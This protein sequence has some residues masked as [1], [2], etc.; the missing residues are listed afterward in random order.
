MT[1][2]KRKHIRLPDYDYSTPGAYFV[3]ICT[4]NRR[5]TLSEITVGEGL[6]PPETRLSQIGQCVEEQIQHLPHRYPTVEIEK[7]VI[8]PNHVHLLVTIRE[9]TENFNT[10]QEGIFQELMKR[11]CLGREVKREKRGP[12]GEAGPRG[13]F[14]VFSGEQ[15]RRTN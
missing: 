4:E 7:Y 3:T 10:V 1:L 13:G 6:V 11:P 12:A 14:I 5:C 15:L 9:G 2:P 8:M